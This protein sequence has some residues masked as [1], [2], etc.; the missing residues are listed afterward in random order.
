[1]SQDHFLGDPILD[2][3]MKV[4]MR[5]ARE[6]YVTKDRLAIIERQL[7]RAGV[8]ATDAIEKFEPDP[9]TQSSIY[10]QRDA[11]IARILEPLTQR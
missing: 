11:F 8:I 9:E 3:M 6:L 10:L 7:E 1:M 4:T 5:L 2:R